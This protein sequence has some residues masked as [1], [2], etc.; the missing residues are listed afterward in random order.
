M[1]GKRD[2][3]SISGVKELINFSRIRFD[4][5][6]LC[7]IPLPEISVGISGSHIDLVKQIFN[8]FLV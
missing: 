5:I 2:I 3:Y 6:C 1:I 7:F 4:R 8:A